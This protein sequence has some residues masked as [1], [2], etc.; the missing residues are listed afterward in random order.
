VSRPIVVMPDAPFSVIEYLRS[1][2]EVTNLVPG[3]RITT[4]FPPNPVFPLVQIQRIG[5]K[6]LVKEYVDEP[7]IQVDVYGGTQEQCSLIMRTV[8][9]AILAIQN[10]IVSEGVLVSGFEETGPAWLPDTVP[11]PPL[12]RFVARFQIL[13]HP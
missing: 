4:A 10:D 5:G 9:A 12:S 7:S 2:A 13:V 6:S 3:S 1:K 8:R 11:T